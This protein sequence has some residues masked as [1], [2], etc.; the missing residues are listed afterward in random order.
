MATSNSFLPP[1]QPQWPNRSLIW[2]H[3]QP[4]GGLLVI[5]G[6]LFVPFLIGISRVG[7]D[8]L[9]SM[10]NLFWALAY[11]MLVP[12]IWL[13]PELFAH[14]ISRNSFLMASAFVATLSALWSL[15][16]ELSAL[17]GILLILNILAGFMAYYHLGLRRM[18]ILVFAYLLIMQFGSTLLILAGHPSASDHLGLKKG[19]YLHKNQLALHCVLLFM[20]SL[21]LFGAGWRRLLT[22]GAA[23]LACFNLV[24][25]GSGTGVIVVILMT[26]ILLGCV[27]VSSGSRPTLFFAGAG[28]ILTALGIGALV[29]L[30][31]DPYTQVLD[32]LGKDGTLTGRTTLWD[33]ALTTFAD[34]PLLGIGY[35]AYWNSPETTATSLWVVTGQHLESFHNNFLDIMVAVGLVGLITFVVAM[36]SLLARTFEQF[37][38]SG[39]ALLAWPFAFMCL[40]TIYCMSEYPLYWNNE[41]Q[42][43]MAFLAASSAARSME[44]V[45]SR[46]RAADY[47]PAAVSPEAEGSA[48]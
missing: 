35:F 31:I 32:A 42:F 10:T 12:T 19:L 8:F 7:T 48:L 26:N 33:F 41:F 22:L 23:G 45:Y 39:D 6:L 11:L 21:I 14:S 38:V 9:P 27:I 34:S 24:L 46:D 4:N 1:L 40:M 20:T 44:E 13:R 37:R 28:L 17:R 5:G 25:S 2:E 43:L 3:G 16:P 30:E 18:V 15:T 36:V 47:F 29:L